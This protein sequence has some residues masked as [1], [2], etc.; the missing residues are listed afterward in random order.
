MDTCLSEPLSLQGPITPAPLNRC[1]PAFCVVMNVGHQRHLRVSSEAQRTR[2][3]LRSA[4]PPR[5]PMFS[6]PN[7]EEYF[8]WPTYGP[9]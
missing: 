6:L 8:R 3:R 4:M 1:R 5:R 9:R 2:V 7:V